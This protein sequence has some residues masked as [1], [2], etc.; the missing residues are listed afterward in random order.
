MRMLC[1]MCDGEGMLKT[2]YKK[3]NTYGIEIRLDTYEPCPLC[4]ASG[5]VQVIKAE[6]D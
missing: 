5:E 6:Y 3:T 2:T 1:P 4:I